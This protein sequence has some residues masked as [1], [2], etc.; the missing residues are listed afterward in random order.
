MNMNKMIFFLSLFQNALKWVLQDKK[1]SASFNEGIKFS[2]SENLLTLTTTCDDQIL[3]ARI[4]VETKPGSK[5]LFT[6]PFI[7]L[8]DILKLEDQP[9]I[10]ELVNEKLVRISASDK[11]FDI[12]T[13]EHLKADVS[14][15]QTSIDDVTF[16]LHPQIKDEMVKLQPYQHTNP[17][18]VQ[19]AGIN[20][21]SQAG[22]LDM[23]ATDGHIIRTV[24]LNGCS[25]EF[26]FILPS[27]AVQILVKNRKNSEGIIQGVLSK[28]NN[29]SS[30]SLQVGS[31]FITYH[32]QTL[33][34]DEPY[35]D[36]EKM[37]E[38]AN[39]VFEFEIE[40]L[41]QAMKIGKKLCF[42][43]HYKIKLDIHGCELV[44]ENKYSELLYT[45]TLL[46]TAYKGEPTE[47]VI[48]AQNLAPFFDEE[49]N[50]R[51]QYN[52]E[53][54]LIFIKRGQIR[55]VFALIEFNQYV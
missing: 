28:R 9:I 19:Q 20:F 54:N 53:K 14:V 8:H 27:K 21:R 29:V 38:G 43:D 2:V 52:V 4:P 46:K 3:S 6:I 30:L 1:K 48:S 23:T 50:F 34:T 15:V 7:A 47:F 41:A 22:V 12:E 39:N 37:M 31:R 44:V 13:C 49:G 18:R 24:R 26:N 45:R 32:V 10:V 17:D 25:E 35:P 40:D 55:Y 5:F 33:L 51:A 36:F 11:V 16:I 42:E